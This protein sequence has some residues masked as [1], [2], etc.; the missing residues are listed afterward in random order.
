M[1]LDLLH[2]LIARWFRERFGAPTQPQRLG[3]PAIASGRS[4]LIAAPTG[5]GKTLAAFLIC[6]DRLWREWL[7]GTLVDATQVVYI[8]PL[9]ALSNDIQRNLQNPLAEIAALALSEGLPAPQI[10]AA[11]RTGDTPAGER[12]AMLKRP[13]HILVTTP[14]SL[15]LLLTSERG[16]KSLQQV[17]SVIVDEI[18]ALARDKRGSHLAL[19]LERL[20]ALCDEEPVRIGLSATQRP[21]DE[22]ARFLVGAEHVDAAGVPDCTIVDVGHARELDLALDVPGSELSAVCSHEQWDEVYNRLVALITSH[23]ST[24]V[25]VNTRRL[26]ERVSHHLTELLGAEAVASH[27]GSLSKEIRQSAEARLKAGELRAIVATASL[28]MG[29][30]IGYVDLVC[31]VGSPRSIATFLQR[32]GRSGHALGKIPK[33]RLFPLT[34]DELLESLALVRA[35]HRG[36]LDRIEL[37]EKP[38]DI[39]AQQIVAAVACEEWNET[40]LFERFRRAWPYRNLTAEEYEK[41]LHLVSEGV[42]PNSKRGAYLHRDRIA[43]RLRARR[44]ARIA[45][46]TSGGAIPEM[47]LYRVLAE[48]ERTFV[49]TVDEH[50]AVDSSA[51]DVFLLGGTSWRVAAIRGGEVIVHDAEGAPP[52][53]PFW[54]GEAPGRTLELSTAVSQLR[55]DLAVHADDTSPPD[56]LKEE[57]GASDW[58]AGQALA[59]VGVQL[60]ALG[61]MPTVREVV[62]ER[63]FDESGGMQLVIHAPFGARINRAWGLTLRKRF[64]RSFDFELQA[65]ADDDGILL[66]LGPQHSFAIETLFAMLGPHNAE[67][68]FEQALLA[69]PMFQ[70]RW[71]WNVTRS[72]AVLR[73]QGG[74]RVPPHMQRFRS[75]DLLAAVFPETVGCLEN[76]SGDVTIPDHPLVQQTMYDCKHE[77][78]DIEGF[79]GV[80]RDFKAGNVKFIS[81]D[82][83]EPSPFCYELLNA[84]P[85]AFLDGAG[86]EE[87]RTRA[88]ATRRTLST[89][90]MR[91]LAK[92]DPDAIAA[93]REDAWPTVR[94]P[95]ELHDALM[96]LVTI[97]RVPEWQAWFDKLVASG[98]ASTIHR[99]EHPPLWIA[100]ERWP[101][102]AAAFDHV[103]ADPPITL[104][105][106]LNTPWER[107]AA[108]VE[109]ARGR[110]QHSGPITSEKLAELL[111]LEPSQA[112][113]ALEALEG[114]GIVLRGRFTADAQEIEGLGCNE[115]IEWCERRLLARIHRQ[116]LDGLRRQ[117]KP[118]EPG[119]FWRFLLA[120]QRVDEPSWGGPVGAREALAQL[121]GFEMPA[122]AWEQRVLAARMADY[123]PAWLDQLFMSGEA[124]WG[125]LRP[126]VRNGDDAPTMANLTRTVP[127]SLALR[128]DLP[129]LLPEEREASLEGIRTA[130]QQVIEALVARG[131]LFFNEI[132]R[133]TDLLPSQVEDAL[134]ELAALGVVTSDAFAAVRK[135]VEGDKKN[136]RQSSSRHMPPRRMHNYGA[137]IGRWSL[138]PGHVDPPQREEYLDRW[139]R[140]LLARYGVLFRELLTRET[141]APAWHELVPVLRKMEM[142]GEIRGGRFV[143]N[144]GGEQ[145]A[146]P[147]AVDMLRKRRDEPADEKH[148]IISAADPLNLAGILTPGARIPATHKNAL[149][150]RD[151]QVI[152]TLIAGDVEY[153]QPLDDTQKWELRGALVRGGRPK[154]HS[155]AESPV[156]E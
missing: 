59:Y 132:M 61:I 150:L 12:A 31:Q 122:G 47:T 3:W 72:L 67:Q 57:C 90:D 143:S 151:G 9:K 98:R 149:A 117:I 18:H 14:E 21:M 136:G 6:L 81:R 16:R 5:S 125:R 137:P 74:K 134:R 97:E 46:L 89:A 110:I 114:Q 106:R 99:E 37:P 52:S 155:A 139:C 83:R 131:A 54:F 120:W 41:V 38:F 7:A 115:G 44:G 144:V 119:L 148:T 111:G 33:G 77:A 146:L 118:V 24:L 50:Y 8:S 56:W 123:D 91:D 17:K 126:P 141:A 19:S 133:L 147:A 1:D 70:V 53:V 13:P 153:L 104:A 65:S 94:S 129:W 62:F 69:A 88:V 135:I 79:M 29:I 80:L 11:V 75:D 49:G 4:T 105:A 43:N 107:D 85:Y 156:S 51:G 35:V 10:R 78:A 116:T 73:Q 76:H 25:F 22:I 102:V 103:T 15:Y 45:A 108:W 93:V 87:R 28:E 130:G 138:F 48:P 2:P 20:D 154:R 71:R 42:A 121:Q 36:E 124:V 63:F 96:S 64:C 39:L 127:I 32:V 140:Q 68:L 100:A 101:L 34:R 84:N 55:S 27:H 30:D 92:L 109:L 113:S 142:R 128:E 58:A 152:A 145:Y 26:A 40:E 112:F 23:R 86:L 66:S 82:T 60:A 95:D